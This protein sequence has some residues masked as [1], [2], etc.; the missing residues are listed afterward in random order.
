[1][2]ELYLDDDDENQNDS[3][4]EE[5]EELT[6]FSGAGAAGGGGTV[7]LGKMHKKGTPDYTKKDIKKFHAHA[8]K[9]YGKTK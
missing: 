1:M 4:D 9:S 2:S 3:L 8:R 6:E 7:P 5:D